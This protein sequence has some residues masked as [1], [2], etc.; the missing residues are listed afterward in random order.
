LQYLDA[1]TTAQFKDIVADLLKGIV[2]EIL[3]GQLSEFN[4]LSAGIW[5]DAGA[6]LNG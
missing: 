6:K 2:K 1:N 5:K 3:D 4:D